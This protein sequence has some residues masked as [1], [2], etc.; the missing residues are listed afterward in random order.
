MSIGARVRRAFGPHER[1]IS[2]LWRAMFVDIDA[3]AAI[4]H[5]WAPG[6]TRILEIGCGEGY[7]TERLVKLWPDARIDAI[8][9]AAVR[10]A[11]AAMLTSPPTVA[12]IGRVGKVLGAG[13]VARRLG[14]A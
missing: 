4:C 3:W 8:D 6:A 1:L 7:S 9:V 5:A 14:H 11:G 12:A 13:G 2:E 10:R